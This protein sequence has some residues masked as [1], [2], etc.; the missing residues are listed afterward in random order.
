LQQ[1][2]RN[3]YEESRTVDLNDLRK[4]KEFKKLEIID[5]KA[6]NWILNGYREIGPIKFAIISST[7]L[8]LAYRQTK[9]RQLPD[10]VDYG[11]SVLLPNFS[12]KETD[13]ILK[14]LL[15]DV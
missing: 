2:I 4:I 11:A 15:M 12:K 9:K 8:K 14:E 3:M 13:A 5:E 7:I 10:L 6:K 1:C